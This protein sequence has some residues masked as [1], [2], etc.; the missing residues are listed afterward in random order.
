M[1]LAEGKVPEDVILT[2][3]YARSTPAEALWSSTD[4]R[5]DP[6]GLYADVVQALGYGNT[7]ENRLFVRAVLRRYQRRQGE[8]SAASVRDQS[9]FSNIPVGRSS[10]IFFK[11]DGELGGFD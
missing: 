5:D 4:P 9:L 8:P 10:C 7:R 3:V 2:E 6:R 1:Q 11:D